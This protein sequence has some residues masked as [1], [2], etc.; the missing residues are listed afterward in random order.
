MYFY[1]WFINI[2]NIASFF[3][4]YYF[5]EF[6]SFFIGKR[7]L[8]RIIPRD[9]IRAKIDWRF[10]EKNNAL[11]SKAANRFIK[12]CSR[13]ASSLNFPTR[14]FVILQGSMFSASLY[15]LIHL[16]RVCMSIMKMLIIS[17]ADQIR[18]S[19]TFWVSIVLKIITIY[20]HT[21]NIIMFFEKQISS[22]LNPSIYNFP[23]DILFSHY[24]I[25]YRD[26][27]STLRSWRLGEKRTQWKWNPAVSLQ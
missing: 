1:T 15:F 11:S 10:T 12:T 26:K 9:F 23:F 20:I 5:A 16:L 14:Y 21:D 7:L 22:R 13:R 17:T 19:G 4:L 6:I 24:E 25:I 2:N 8:L 27:V 18:W 3:T